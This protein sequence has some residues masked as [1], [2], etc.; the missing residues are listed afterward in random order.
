MCICRFGVEVY[1]DGVVFVEY[2]C[3]V[4]GMCGSR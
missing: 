2:Y 3:D 4:E 1:E